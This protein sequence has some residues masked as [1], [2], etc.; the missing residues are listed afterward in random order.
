MGF[1]SARIP[2]NTFNNLLHHAAIYVLL[3]ILTFTHSTLNIMTGIFIVTTGLFYFVGWAVGKYEEKEQTAGTSYNP[4][5][6]ERVPIAGAG[7]QQGGGAKPPAQQ[8]SAYNF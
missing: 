1:G 6:G 5:P 8:N 2:T 3:S 7:F 4:V